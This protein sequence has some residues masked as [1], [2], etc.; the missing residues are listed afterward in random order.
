M[1]RK[2]ENSTIVANVTPPGRGGV[3]I[4]RISGPKASDIATAMLGALPQNRYATFTEFKNEDDHA[5]DQG[6]ALFFKGPHSFTG[7][8]VL[9][10]QG[11]GGPVVMDMILQTALHWGA[12]VAEPGEFSKR[13]FLNDKMDLSQA[14]AIADLINASSKQ[15]AQCAVRS[16]SGVFS[17]KIKSLL[18]RLIALRMMVEA[19]IDF[20]EEEIDF[21]GESSLINDTLKL[22][23]DL[24]V[25]LKTTEQGALLQEGFSMVIAGPPNAGKSSLMNRFCGEHTAI[26]TDIA[27][28]TRDLLRE[29]IELDGLPIHIVDTAGLH[30]SDNAVE[31]EGIRRALDETKKADLI[32]FVL[33]SVQAFNDSNYIAAQ[34]LKL[35]HNDAKD[36]LIVFNKTDLLE[37]TQN[38][39]T[40]SHA[41]FD[42]IGV[43]VK[44]EQ[45]MDA[46]IQSIKQRAGYSTQNEGA[47]IARARHVAAIKNTREAIVRGVAV[48][49][50]QKASELLAEELK[51]A[52]ESLSLITG[53][54]RSDDLLGAIFSEF[55]IGK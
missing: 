19:A 33:D 29:Y 42:V 41:D 10:L 54:Y 37:T 51:L 6:I 48:Y 31:I 3:G 11:H 39:D 38:I 9:E 43:S 36:V 35:N 52:Q 26:V 23:D 17:E 15:A 22:I 14:E 7:E 44:K 2:N 53:E 8:D 46:L 18:K 45:G 24:G 1:L 4:V 20:V 12:V 28:T 32:L 47:F 13:A 40:L 55:C 5:I 49:Q 27:G 50:A 25:I 34:L 16:L 21:L 30:E